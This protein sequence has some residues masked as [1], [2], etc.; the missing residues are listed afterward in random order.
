MKT[1]LLFLAILIPFFGCRKAEKQVAE[2]EKIHEINIG[3]PVGVYN[4]KDSFLLNKR[5]GYE[6]P[7]FWHINLL[8]DSFHLRKEYHYT[9]RP[10]SIYQKSGKYNF[11]DNRVIERFVNLAIATSNGAIFMQENDDVSIHGPA[12]HIIQYRKGSVDK[13]FFFDKHSTAFKS[14]IDLTYTL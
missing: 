8:T 13:I 9:Y 11:N 1:A 6:I 7:Y 4:S 14:L 3:Y 5:A 2:Q 10:D 12:I